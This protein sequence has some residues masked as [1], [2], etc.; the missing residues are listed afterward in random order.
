VLLETL[1]IAQVV[2]LLATWWPMRAATRVDAV[3]A[4]QYE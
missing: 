2:S 3:E 4:L 1:V